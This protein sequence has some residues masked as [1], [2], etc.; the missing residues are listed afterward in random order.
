MKRRKLIKLFM[1]DGWEFL[2]EG[3]NHEIWT[4]G[5]DIEQIPRKREINEKLARA[6]I[7]KWNLK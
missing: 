7:R 3:R 4:N 5:K 2:R 1:A 6:L